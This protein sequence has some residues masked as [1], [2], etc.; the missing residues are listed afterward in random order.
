[1][2]TRAM[3]PM[4]GLDWLKRGLNLG[5]HNPKAIFGGAA[6]LVAAVFVVALVVS[7]LMS[8]LAAAFGQGSAGAMAIG[9]LTIVLMLLAMSILMVGYFR[10]L[11][12]VEHGQPA[13]ALDVLAGFRD[14][15]TSGRMMGFMLSLTVLQNLLLLVVVGTLASD[16]GAWYLANM[17]ASMGAGTPAPM[18]APPAGFGLAFVV[19][20]IIGLFCYAVQAIGFGQIA[21]RG[22]GIGGALAD[23]GAGAAKNLLPLLVFALTMFAA[24][25]LL[26]V[27]ILLVAGIGGLLVKLLGTWVG[28]LLGVP[29]YAAFIIGVVVV[30]FGVMYYLWRDVAGGGEPPA[31]KPADSGHHIEL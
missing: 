20:V 19:I 22:R 14:L 1:M 2:T 24:M 16:F 11:D 7:L 6:V 18:T 26:G 13:R 25:L 8:G 17:Q 3:G 12:A 23:G 5:R 4:A 21:L 10:L 15:P 31:V 28:I 9:L 30:M 27:A 29:L